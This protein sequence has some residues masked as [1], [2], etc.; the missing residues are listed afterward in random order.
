MEDYKLIFATRIRRIVSELGITVSTL[1]TKTQLGRNFML[2]SN[3]AYNKVADFLIKFPQVSAEWLFRGTGEPLSKHPSVIF[4][5]SEEE[6]SF[7]TSL[8]EPEV[9]TKKTKEADR[10]QELIDSLRDQIAQ[11][12]VNI[13]TKDAYINLLTQQINNQ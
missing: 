10:T 9:I 12:K 11:L 2:N 5:E 1:E 13:A 8:G 4:Y 7:P 6:P 3:P